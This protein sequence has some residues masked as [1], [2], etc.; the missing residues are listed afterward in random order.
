VTTEYTDP[1]GTIADYLAL[2]NNSIIVIEK[3][4][5]PTAGNLHNIRHKPTGALLAHYDTHTQMCYVLKKGFKDHCTRIG[6]NATK[7]LNDLHEGSGGEERVVMEPHT[8][9]TLGAGTE[10]AT[11]Q[12]WCFTLNM[13]HP[14]VS[15]RVDLEVIEGGG[16][17]QPGLR[18]V[19]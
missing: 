11:A 7:I 4:T 9:R 8:R 17:G 15:G 10:Y 3:G 1:L 5:H 14:E 18:A 12:V 16:A 19:R 13:R 2:I 6:A